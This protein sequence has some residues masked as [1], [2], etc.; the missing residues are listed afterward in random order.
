MFDALR[1]A[2][3]TSKAVW[4]KKQDDKDSHEYTP[5]SHHEA[6]YL[7]TM[8]GAR[9]KLWRTWVIFYIPAYICNIY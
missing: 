1:M 4:F 3:H 9:G 5:L 6:L 8:G 2:L 7:A